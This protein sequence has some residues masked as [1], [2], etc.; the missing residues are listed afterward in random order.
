MRFNPPLQSGH[1]LRRYKRFLTDIVISDGEE[2]TIHCPNTGSM[3]NCQ[4]EN[5]RVWFSDSK[6]PKRK[7]PCTWE[8]VE[9]PVQY[10]DSEKMSLACV[11]T[12]RANALVQEAIENHTIPE[13]TGYKT[14][15]REVKYGEE[16][17][18]IDLLLSD[19]ENDEKPDC[20]IEVKS[21]TLATNNGF[22]EFP[23]AV[24][25]RGQKHLR[26]LEAM[27]AAGYRAVLFFCVQHTGIEVVSPADSIDPEYGK[28]LRQAMA[29][30]V[31]VIVWGSSITS[32]EII[33]NRPL[34][35][36]VDDV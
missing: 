28:A 21:V 30:G 12:G 14:L 32:E 22:G 5:A 35:L 29:A 6:N 8:L 31:E 18:R 20:Y 4:P 23:D 9:I 15:K 25:T 36:K 24:T 26:E 33:L 7:L 16:S 17:S 3:K 34:T 11:N 2:I 19:S 1:L 13:L 27:V 10:G